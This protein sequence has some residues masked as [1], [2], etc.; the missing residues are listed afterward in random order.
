MNA[1]STQVIIE[2]IR[3]H[4]VAKFGTPKSILCDRESIF[5]A[6]TFKKYV[7]TTL[8]S[9]LYYT[10]PQY[11]QGNGV[12]ESSHRVLETAIKTYKWDEHTHVATVIAD[13]TII[14]N[15][16]PNRELGDTP[17]SLVF[18]TDIRI[19]G[20]KAYEPEFDEQARLT[21]LRNYR[22]LRL[23]IDQ[24]LTLEEIASK[25]LTNSNTPKFKIGDI[26]TFSLTEQ[27]RKV[28]QHVTEERKYAA[29]R[30]FPHRIT[31][32][33]RNNITAEPLWTYDKARTAPAE[34]CKLI[35]TFIPHLLR[36]E[37]QRLYP[38][39][40]PMIDCTEET[41]EIVDLDLESPTSQ[42]DGSEPFTNPVL[43]PSSKRLRQSDDS[44]VNQLE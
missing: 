32:V 7:K 12:N 11:P 37:A 33:T 20:L 2:A 23:L 13:A 8:K 29:I 28:M 40:P 14:Y 21:Q 18:G 41:P 26:V 31:H 35:A 44:S 3:D 15:S 1:K 10:S 39:L 34:Q 19:P 6:N 38:R 42:P 27:E 25:T 22:G 9:T 43:P 16:T 24:L 5:T 36:E 30:S 17:A 4:W